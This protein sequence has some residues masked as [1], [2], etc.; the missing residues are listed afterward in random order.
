VLRDQVPV[1]PVNKA[2][3]EPLE[4]AVRGGQV[5]HIDSAEVCCRALGFVVTAGV[6]DAGAGAAG[7]FL[8]AHEVDRELHVAEALFFPRT[9]RRGPVQ[10]YSA[11]TAASAANTSLRNHAFCGCC[12]WRRLVPSINPLTAASAAPD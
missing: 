10:I 4:V 3:V 9:C 5:E 11:S 1:G 8:L 2:A 12:F 6:V 7:G